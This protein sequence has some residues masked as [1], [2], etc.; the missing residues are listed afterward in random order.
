MNKL[1][2]NTGNNFIA[3][4]K[5][6]SDKKEVPTIIFLHGLMSNMNGEKALALEKYAIDKGY[7]FIRFDNFGHGSSSGK[8]TDQT[9]SSWLEGLV[10][11]IEKLASDKIIII[12]SSMGAWIGLL[13]AIKFPEKIAGL[14]CIAAAADFTEELIWQ[15]LTEAEKAEF[16]QNGSYT[17]KG[18]NQGCHTPYPIS[19][20]LITDGRKNLLLADNNDIPINCPVHFIHGMQD[21]DVPYDISLRIAEKLTSHDVI[22]KLIKDADHKLSR[23]EDL[24]IIFESLEYCIKH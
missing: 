9:I 18:K 10:L 20:K 15:A 17:I 11:V 5:H 2:D 13:G 6:I 7:E 14:V 3:Y 16:I 4:N 12:G 19:L 8:F 1:Y 24:Q 22:I 21:F 23:P